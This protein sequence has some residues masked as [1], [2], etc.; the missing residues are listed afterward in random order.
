MPEATDNKVDVPTEPMCAMSCE[1]DRIADGLRSQWVGKDIH[2]C[3]GT[4]DPS[5]TPAKVSS[6]AGEARVQRWQQYRR[7]TIDARAEMHCKV[8]RPPF[9]WARATHQSIA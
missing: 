6:C 1:T 4:N 3:K 5:R 7:N 8:Q 2:A 9:I